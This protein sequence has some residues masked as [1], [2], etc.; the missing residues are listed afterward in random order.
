MTNH[1]ESSDMYGSLTEVQSARRGV[2][3][4]ARRDGLRVSHTSD[5]RAPGRLCTWRDSRGVIARRVPGPAR[6]RRT[7]PGRDRRRE[8]GARATG[9][10]AEAA[11][12]GARAS[13]ECQESL[14]VSRCTNVIAAAMY[15]T[16][17]CTYACWG[18]MH[19]I[20]RTVF[21]GDPT[22][23]EPSL[24]YGATGQRRNLGGLG[25]AQ[26]GRRR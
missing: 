13:R 11:G 6:R 10:R 17:Y 16:K 24:H 4:A 25:A 14:P 12:G 8:Q 3:H 9:A 18:S 15:R 1:N 23:L 22:P 7:G 26:L 19:T 20:I 2:T 5:A 21:R